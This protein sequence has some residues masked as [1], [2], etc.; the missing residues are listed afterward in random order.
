M[1][2]KF[3]A[4]FVGFLPPL[5]SYPHVNIKKSTP[6]LNYTPTEETLCSGVNCGFAAV[7]QDVMRIIEKSKTVDS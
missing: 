6:K 5:P 4:E 7:I 2:K 3:K 1:C